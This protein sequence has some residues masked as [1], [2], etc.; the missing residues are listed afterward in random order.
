M[1]RLSIDAWLL[2][3]QVFLENASN[4]AE[5]LEGVGDRHAQAYYTKNFQTRQRIAS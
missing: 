3:A 2:G 1:P 5:I 4:N